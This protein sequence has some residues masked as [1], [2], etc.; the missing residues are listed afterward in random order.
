MPK[1]V[2]TPAD[3]AREFSGTF[4][5]PESGARGERALASFFCC[6]EQQEEEQ[7]VAGG[8]PLHQRIDPESVIAEDL[9]WYS[10]DAVVIAD[11]SDDD[12][13]D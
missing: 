8:D 13:Y 11:D 9:P 7:R 1:R 3:L 5:S 12:D 6:E 2:G 4:L 10:D